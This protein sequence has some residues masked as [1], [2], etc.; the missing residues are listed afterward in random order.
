MINVIVAQDGS[1]L[2]QVVRGAAI[3]AVIPVA[4]WFMWTVLQPLMGRLMGALGVI[5]TGKFNDQN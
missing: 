4:F 2:E 1:A 5:L 3:W